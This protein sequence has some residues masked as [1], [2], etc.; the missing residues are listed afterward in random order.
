MT[1]LIPKFQQPMADAIN[2]PI[3][4]KFA[5][6]V[7]VGDFI[8]LGTTTY[9][10]DCSAY[11]NNALEALIAKGGGTLW[12]P[13]AT[14]LVNLNWSQY[15]ID[16]G[17]RGINIMGNN[18]LLLG[19]TGA[20]A[21]FTIDRGGSGD[22][23]IFSNMSFYD[24]EFRTESNVCSGGVPVI[25]YA[26]QIKRS[27]ANWYNCIFSGGSR[28]AYYGTNCQYSTWIGCN[29]I[30]SSKTPAGGAPSAGCWIQSSYTNETAADQLTY[31]R[32]IF[33][34][35][36]NGLYIQGCQQLRVLNSRF[37]L[38]FDGGEGGIV[39]KDYL[40]GVGSEGILID[41][42][43]FEFCYVRDI[44]LLNQTS[45][46]VVSNNVFGNTI[47]QFASKVAVCEQASVFASYYNNDT[48]TADG[49]IMTLT[50]NNS[51]FNYI[52]NDK[53]PYSLTYAGSNPQGIVQS[54]TIGAGFGSGIDFATSTLGISG[55]YG[56]PGLLFTSPISG[57]SWLWVDGS[58]NLRIKNGSAPT[59]AT[60]G[61]VVG[62]QT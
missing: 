11:F 42:C 58:G 36:Q 17:Y 41:S 8:P 19:V 5:E 20:T 2:R 38:M 56:K 54:L 53:P 37:Q 13:F 50:G 59:T 7:S 33:S 52:G 15:V 47:G 1:T 29:F 3:D 44:Y 25:S 45:R 21:V 51:T 28:S 35:N 24:L 31:D 57:G 49:P 43:H 32:C 4:L 40:D 62:T 39:I 10:T 22:N 46:T 26:V 30:C 48:R 60:D 18:S 61:V 55:Y 6:T 34:A 12:I 16:G 23:M 9:N 14:Y 27:A